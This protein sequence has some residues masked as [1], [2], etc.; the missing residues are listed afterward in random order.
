MAGW[1]RKLL[2]ACAVL[3][4]VHESSFLKLCVP[5]RDND[6]IQ[7]LTIIPQM[8]VKTLILQTSKILNTAAKNMF[9]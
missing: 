4:T 5:V 6:V 9:D 1:V 7:S 2:S 8:L 3:C